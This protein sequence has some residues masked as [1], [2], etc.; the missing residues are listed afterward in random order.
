[1]PTSSISRRAATG[2][3]MLL[4]LTPLRK[5]RD[6][7]LLFIG[8]VVSFLGTMITYV[9]VPYQVYE[10]TKSNLMVGLLGTVQP[11]PVLIFGLIGGS[12]ADAMD[13][14]RLLLISEALMSLG[15]LG[16]AI[17]AALPEPAFGPSSSSPRSCRR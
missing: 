14:R 2:T 5:Y 7:R 8:Q 6:F 12:V 15:A 17:N 4:D 10:L 13:R 11:V 16:L 1:M 9:A 3:E